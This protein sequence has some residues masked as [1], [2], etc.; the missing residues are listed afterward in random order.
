M[1]P[2]KVKGNIEPGTPV[3]STRIRVGRNI[4]GYGLS[5]GITKQQRIDVEKLMSNALGKLSGILLASTIHSLAWTRK[6][7]NSLLMIISS[8]S[9]ETET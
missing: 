9:M 2:S 3:H 7:D 4:D 1:D 8:S 5:P 6:S